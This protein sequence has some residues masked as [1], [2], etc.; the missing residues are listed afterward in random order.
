MNNR[1]HFVIKQ[2]S[3][4][5]DLSTALSLKESSKIE[6][7]N[8]FVTWRFENVTRDETVVKTKDDGTQ[9]NI[10]FQPGYWSF[11]LIQSRL[12][13][14]DITLTRLEHN[15]SCRIF[16]QD[17]SLQL[18]LVDELL[19]FGVNKTIAKNTFTDSK[20]VNINLGVR[21]VNIGCSLVNSTRNWDRYQ[22]GS[23]V[24]ATIPLPT[25]MALNGSI[26][27]FLTQK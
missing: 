15:N 25:D 2:G 27:N 26:Q 14:E 10:I 24:V 6:I 8:L 3:N 7:S 21:S 1:H 20:T 11:S 4:N 19:G 17:E 5:F 16:W 9:T 18:G 13:E 23:E 22:E 12:A